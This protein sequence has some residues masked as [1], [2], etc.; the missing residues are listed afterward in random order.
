M[1][2]WLVDLFWCVFGVVCD[3]VICGWLKLSLLVGVWGLVGLR[4]CWELLRIWVVGFSGVDGVDSGLFLG[5][6]WLFVCCMGSWCVG[7]AHWGFAGGFVRFV[8]LNVPR[9]F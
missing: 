5:C 2:F 4:C 6:V 9:P 8:R 3:A 7:E 1:H